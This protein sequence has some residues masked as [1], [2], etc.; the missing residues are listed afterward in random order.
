MAVAASKAA[1]V[2]VTEAVGVQVTVDGMRHPSCIGGR[3]G[4]T[5]NQRSADSG[6]ISYSQ[7]GDLGAE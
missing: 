7:M 2:A 1:A 3:Q 6:G 4:Y 5:T